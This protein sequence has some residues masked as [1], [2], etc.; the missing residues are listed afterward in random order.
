MAKCI[1]CSR[2]GFFIITDKDGLCKKCVESIKNEAISKLNIL[3][4][5]EKIIETTENIDTIISK[6]E[7]IVDLL[8]DFKKYEN[9]GIRIFSIPIKKAIP[10]TCKE[11]D[12]RLLMIIN[13]HYSRISYKVRQLDSKKTKAELVQKYKT[14]IDKV[15]NY[16]D[17]RPIG[18]DYLKMKL[19]NQY[20]ALWDSIM[21]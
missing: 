8:S 1:W 13:Q 7:L 20:T 16:L 9:K 3:Q 6:A 18:N 14:E 12:N 17:R 5:S 15:I 4:M 19:L 10:G 21:K 11:T 2:S